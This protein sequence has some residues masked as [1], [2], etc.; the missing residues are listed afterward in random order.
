MYDGGKTQ[1][2]SYN[3]S[4]EYRKTLPLIKY[5]YDIC[6]QRNSSKYKELMKNKIKRQSDVKYLTEKEIEGITKELDL[7]NEKNNLHFI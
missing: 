1:E 2:L 5:V 3:F 4:Q 6:D 7:D